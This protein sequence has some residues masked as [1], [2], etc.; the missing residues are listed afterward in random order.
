MIDP[1]EYLLK[2]NSRLWMTVILL[3]VGEIVLALCMGGCGNVTATEV[4]GK[5]DAGNGGGTTGQADTR[6]AD[7]GSVDSGTRATDVGYTEATGGTGGATGDAGQSLSET[8]NGGAQATPDAQSNPMADSRVAET[9]PAIGDRCGN[10]ATVYY[11]AC[12]PP[13][14]DCAAKYGKRDEWC[15]CAVNPPADGFMTCELK[16]GTFGSLHPTECVFTR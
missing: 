15:D 16:N 1:I 4:N 14:V 2:S 12:C 9:K 3:A 6:G 7:T 11:I 8:G 10:Y 5:G 13:G